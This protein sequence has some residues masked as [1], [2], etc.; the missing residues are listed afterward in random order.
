[1]T[2]DGHTIV[3]GDTLRSKFGYIVTVYRDD[4]GSLSGR[5]VCAPGH[6]CEDIPYY[7]G[8]EEHHTLVLAAADGEVKP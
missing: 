4:D 1:M 3:P 6:P 8:G 2:D 5:L 7:V